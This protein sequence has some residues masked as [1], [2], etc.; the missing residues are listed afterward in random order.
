MHGAGVEPEGEQFRDRPDGPRD[1]VRRSE[2][3]G[4]FQVGVAAPDD[5]DAGHLLQRP[6]V[7]AGDLAAADDADS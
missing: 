2:C 5:L 4:P 1:A 3:P 6:R 7:V